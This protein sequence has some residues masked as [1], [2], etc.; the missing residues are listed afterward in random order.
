MSEQFEQYQRGVYSPE[1]RKILE[2]F[3]QSLDALNDRGELDFMAVIRGD[4]PMDDPTVKCR[5]FY[6]DPYEA[7]WNAKA[8]DPKNQIYFDLDAALK[9]GYE[10]IPAT[11][12]Y[13]TDYRAI[14]PAM[15]RELR[16]HMMV[17]GL[18]HTYKLYKPVYGGDTVYYFPCHQSFKDI[19]PDGTHKYRTFALYGE[20]RGY[21]QKG[22]L[23]FESRS[24]VKESLSRYVDREKGKDVWD[25]WETPDWWARPAHYYTE[26]DWAYIQDLWKK[27]YHRFDEPLYWEDV[28]VGDRP[29]W[30]CF[31]PVLQEDMIRLYGCDD[32]ITWPD[33]RTHIEEGRLERYRRDPKDGIWYERGGPFAHIGDG[34]FPEY[35][36]CFYNTINRDF[37]CTMLN[38]WIGYHGR[39]KNIAWGIMTYMPGFEDEIPNFP[40]YRDPFEGI[41]GMEGKKVD[42]HGMTGDVAIT[43]GYVTGKRIDE[44][45]DH[46]ADLVWWAETIE[47]QLYA[48][49]QATVSL[50][51]KN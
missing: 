21:N 42:T 39:I 36:L 38:N 43:K 50:P 14:L 18:S 37:A 41:P 24:R 31:G 20:G 33:L 44:D 4:I 30:T 7:K 16:D 11:P 6:V 25:P 1:D 27:E 12:V 35:R 29:A 10:G 45:G 9:A 2:D 47:G 32:I 8:H 13:H 22:E 48:E 26:E 49:G 17:S 34:R 51:V 15:P 46:V 5:T 19:T 3:Q 28:N 23:L 40:E